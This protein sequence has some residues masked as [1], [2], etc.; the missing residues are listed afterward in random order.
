M[1]IVTAP[2][3]RSNRSFLFPY[4]RAGLQLALCMCRVVLAPLWFALAEDR[5]II[6]RRAT[7]PLDSE[8]SY[9]DR[10][11]RRRKL[12]G[13]ANKRFDTRDCVELALLEATRCA[14]N[15]EFR[16]RTTVICH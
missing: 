6:V 9:H 12:L 13:A 7:V 14:L 2:L 3:S 15:E 16:I 4:I 5:L 1:T 11:C 8:R 10:S